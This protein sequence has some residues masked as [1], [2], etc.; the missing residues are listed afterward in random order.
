VAIGTAL[1]VFATVLAAEVLGIWLVVG[2]VGGAIL[3][4]AVVVAGGSAVAVLLR[5]EGR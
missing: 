3:G 1:A 4:F 2:Q 5:S